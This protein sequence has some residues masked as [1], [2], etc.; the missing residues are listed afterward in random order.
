MFAHLLKQ[1]LIAKLGKFVDG[2]DSENISVAILQGDFE[3]INVGLKADALTQFQLPFRIVKGYISRLT[4]KVTWMKL[5]SEPV[6]V[7]LEGVYIV[8][9][10]LLTK[11]W[12]FDEVVITSLKKELIAEFELKIAQVNLSARELL[13]QRSYTEKLTANILDN[14]QVTVS[15]IHICLEDQEKGMSLGA[16]LEE[17]NL[18]TTDSIWEAHFANRQQ[19][20]KIDSAIHKRITLERFG[21]YC[22]IDKQAQIFGR[23]ASFDCRSAMK[24][25]I[26]DNSLPFFLEP[27]KVYSVSFDVKIVHNGNGQFMKP[28]YDVQIDVEGLHLSLR[29]QQFSYFLSLL[30]YA[31]A[32]AHFLASQ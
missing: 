30:D 23:P 2:L 25:K 4:A 3:L 17:I 24:S 12:T 6:K 18:R 11:E 32:H 15:N 29:K 14:L 8:L 10:P 9:E 27:S 19:E 26:T 7:D 5:E 1:I 16:I 22:T 13:S 21:L 31:A 28:W 20:A